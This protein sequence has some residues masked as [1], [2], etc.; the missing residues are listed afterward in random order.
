MKQKINEGYDNNEV[1]DVQ[2][3]VINTKDTNDVM[4]VSEKKLCGKT[5]KNGSLPDNTKSEQENM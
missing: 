4:L 5:E 1:T 2:L 3:T